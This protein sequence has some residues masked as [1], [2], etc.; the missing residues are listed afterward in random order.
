MISTHIPLFHSLELHKFLYKSATMPQLCQ[1]M[2]LLRD[3]FDKYAGQDGN[4]TLSKLELSKLLHTEFP[5]PG[6]ANMDRFY[7]ALDNDGDGAVDFKEFV[8][9]VAALTVMMED[10]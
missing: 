10:Q 9:F 2:K 1:A 7:A 5:G 8:T 4:K 3:V 6:G